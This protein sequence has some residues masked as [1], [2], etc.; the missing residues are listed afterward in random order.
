MGIITG[1]DIDLM[2]ESGRIVR[3][4]LDEMKSFIEIGRAH[5]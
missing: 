4:A 2:K 5:V 3:L 1:G